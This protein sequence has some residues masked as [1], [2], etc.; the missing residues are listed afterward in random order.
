MVGIRMRWKECKAWTRHRLVRWH[1]DALTT[2]DS[3]S[4]VACLKLPS[5]F[6]VCPNNISSLPLSKS[7]L[8]GRMA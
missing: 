6:S 8:F 4:S 7:R 1:E 2:S 3:F 5:S